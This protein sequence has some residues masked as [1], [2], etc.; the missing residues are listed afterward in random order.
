ML[1]WLTEC[2]ERCCST[3]QA[4]DRHSAQDE[5]FHVPQTQRFC[6][7]EFKYWDPKITT[8]PGLYLL[9]TPYAKVVGWLQG[10]LVPQGEAQE[11]CS[12]GVLRSLNV[13]L[14][15]GFFAVMQQLYK[16]LHHQA[17]SEDATL[18]VRGCALSLQTM[19]RFCNPTNV[20]ACTCMAC[21][22]HRS[23]PAH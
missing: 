17:I 12:T 22:L 4:E 20:L 9:S 10:Y 5:W 11:L 18:M 13:L 1:L 16:R 19:I 23:H 14:A 3:D 21:L 7:G 2:T 15:A 8:F 6:R